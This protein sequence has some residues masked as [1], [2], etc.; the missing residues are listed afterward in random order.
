MK[1]NKIGGNQNRYMVTSLVKAAV[2]P[3]VIIVRGSKRQFI[4]IY[5]VKIN[6]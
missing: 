6:P 5:K 4:K 2:F 1:K 3:E